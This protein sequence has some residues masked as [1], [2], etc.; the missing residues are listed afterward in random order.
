MLGKHSRLI[1][2]PSPLSESFLVQDYHRVPA[3]Y[4]HK[5]RLHLPLLPLLN[6]AAPLPLS[7]F[8]LTNLSD[9][10]TTSVVKGERPVDLVT[11]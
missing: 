5:A 1:Y 7:L 6:S 9:R 10:Q 8:N 11:T 2:T 3:T 4:K